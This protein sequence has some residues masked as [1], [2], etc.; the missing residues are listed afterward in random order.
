MNRHN[1]RMN[2]RWWL[3]AQSILHRRHRAAHGEPSAIALPRFQWMRQREPRLPLCPLALGPRRPDNPL[4]RMRVAV[5]TIPWRQTIGRLSEGQVQTKVRRPAIRRDP[6]QCRAPRPKYRPRS[7][8]RRPPRSRVRRRGP[9]F[10]KFP[11]P[12]PAVR[13]MDRLTPRSSAARSFLLSSSL[14]SYGV[15][16]AEPPFQNF[17]PQFVSDWH[18]LTAYLQL[19]R[20]IATAIDTKRPEERRHESPPIS[21]MSDAMETTS[22]DQHAS[23]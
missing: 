18:R 6:N 19:P 14:F 12:H 7:P 9:L 8:V 21:I 16:K 22:G 3:P 4:I 1:H 10:R 11:A 20:R 2:R 17:A 13:W 23:K 5:Q 15:G